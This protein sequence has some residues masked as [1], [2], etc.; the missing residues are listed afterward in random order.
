[1]S[2]LAAM[3]TIGAFTLSLLGCASD[4]Q[5]AVEACRPVPDNRASA[6]VSN[7]LDDLE[8]QRAI[9]LGLLDA[10]LSG[11]NQAHDHAQSRAP[12]SS[13]C[14]TTSTGVVNCLSY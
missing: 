6:C 13:N 1:M 14:T 10:G 3:C 2:R 5:L 8:R 4:L 11:Y 12:I 9:G 7:Y